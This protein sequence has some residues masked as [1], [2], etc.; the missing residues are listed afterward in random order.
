MDLRPVGGTLPIYSLQPHKKFQ[1]DYFFRLFSDGQYNNSDLVAIRL[2][3][4]FI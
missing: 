2:Q 1:V 4:G 3:F